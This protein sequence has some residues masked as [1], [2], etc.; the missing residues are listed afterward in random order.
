MTGSLISVK[1]EEL[2]AVIARDYPTLSVRDDGSRIAVEGVLEIKDDGICVESYLIQMVMP[3]ASGGELPKVYEVGGRIPR[4][5]EYHVNGDGSLCLGVPEQ[6]WIEME[7]QLDLA[8]FIEGPLRS[9]FLGA[10]SKLRTG[11]WAYDER[12]HGGAGICEFYGEF[13]GTAEPRRVLALLRMLQANDI[14]SRAACPCGS[15]RSLR[16]CHGRQVHDLR[17]RKLPKEMM[18]RSVKQAEEAAL[19]EAAGGKEN[20]QSQVEAARDRMIGSVVQ[21]MLAKERR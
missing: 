3:V 11:K 21:A 15:G 8:A 14:E 1:A 16:R 13:I 7:G 17:S 10:S 12:T 9:F 4:T 18:A 19:V 20:L 2:R 6:L 5:D